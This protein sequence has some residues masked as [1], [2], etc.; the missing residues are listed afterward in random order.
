VEGVSVTHVIF[1]I[2]G[3]LFSGAREA[4]MPSMRFGNDRIPEIREALG[5]VPRPRGE[6]SHV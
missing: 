2:G 5:L 1:D 6:V 4:G 3:V